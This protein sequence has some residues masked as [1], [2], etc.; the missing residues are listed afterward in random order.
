MSFTCK[1]CKFYFNNNNLPLNYCPNC[2]EKKINVTRF[3]KEANE[4]KKE[5]KYQ[6]MPNDLR[7]F[8]NEEIGRFKLILE[9]FEI[10]E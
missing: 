9:A 8:F 10:K 1:I 7:D 6:E 3:I 2:E 5:S 4:F